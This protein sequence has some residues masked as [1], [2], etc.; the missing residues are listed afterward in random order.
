MEEILDSKEIN[1]AMAEVP[2]AKTETRS[3]QGGHGEKKDSRGSRRDGGRPREQSEF[4][5]RTI[6][7]ARVTRVMAGGKRMRFRALVVIGDHKGGIGYG[8]A[9][10]ADVSLAVSKATAAAKKRLVRIKIKKGTIPHE[11][12]LKYKSAQVFLKPAPEGT[13]IIAGGSVR[14]VLELAGIQNVVSKIYGSN[15]KINNVKATI[16]AL[17]SMK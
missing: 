10:G 15:N 3:A 1:Q 14:T 13:G 6:E 9:K 8:L 11:R 12:T 7:V 4:D 16:E 5:S 17:A 2:V